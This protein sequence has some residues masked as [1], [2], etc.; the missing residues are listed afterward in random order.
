MS[1][2]K[3]AILLFSGLV[4]RY[5]DRLESLK[6]AF[7]RANLKLPFRTYLAVSFLT[8]LLSFLLALVGS[9]LALL[10]LGVEPL[11]RLF[12]VFMATVLATALSLI[13]CIYYPYYRAG[14]RRKSIEANLPFVLTHMGAIA[15]AGVP[16][17]VIFELI[18]NFMEYGE[19][20]V[21]MRRI[22]HNISAFGMDPLTA[23][24]DVIKR[25]PSDELR[26]VLTGFISTSE[27]GGDVRHYL[28]VA[29]ERALFEWRM[30]REKFL[31][32]LTAYAEFYTGVMI[33]APLFIVALFAIM[34]MIQPAIAGVDIATL[35]QISVYGLVPAM[36]IVF[37]AFLRGVEVKI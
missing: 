35:T 20:A 33:A 36:N 23:V 32:Q 24:R 8:T 3:L 2:K 9:F 1:Y 28:K 7:I 6:R 31:R 18:G 25:T 13:A 12:Y 16:P 19:I 15:E 17:H 26:T 21:E 10:L 34:G 30:R 5:V 11:M 27:A 14:C 22:S 29:G 4:D 37:L